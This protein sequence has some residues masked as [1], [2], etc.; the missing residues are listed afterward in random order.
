MIRSGCQQRW[1]RLAAI[2]PQNL[3]PFAEHGEL[4]A[5]WFTLQMPAC[6]LIFAIGMVEPAVSGANSPRVFFTTC[7]AIPAARMRSPGPVS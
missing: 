3:G 1:L 2:C 5:N 4:T 6:V 7:S